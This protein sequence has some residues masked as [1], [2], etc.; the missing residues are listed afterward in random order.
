MIFTDINYK[1]KQGTT[2]QLLLHCDTAFMHRVTSWWNQEVEMQCWIISTNADNKYI[3]V[4]GGAMR[5]KS[6]IRLSMLAKNSNNDCLI[7][8]S[9]L[10]LMP[11]QPLEGA[12]N[13]LSVKSTLQCSLLCEDWGHNNIIQRIHHHTSCIIILIATYRISS[14]RSPQPLLAQLHQTPGLYSRPGCIPGLACISTSTLWLTGG[15]NM[16]ISRRQ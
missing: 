13:K 3:K 1:N 2:C 16:C 14:N 9:F 12:I 15:N 8:L 11:P 6:Y 5:K 10:I 7:H 4:Y